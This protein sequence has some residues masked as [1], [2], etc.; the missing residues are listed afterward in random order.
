MSTAD[1]LDPALRAR[2]AAA[3]DR[4]LALIDALDPEAVDSPEL[5]GGAAAQALVQLARGPAREERAL[6]WAQRAVALSSEGELHYGLYTGLVGV[7][8]AVEQ[9]RPPDEDPNA[10][11]DELL[12][13]LVAE[14]GPDEN[15]DLI[16]GLTGVA[17]LAAERMPAPGAAALLEAVAAVVARRAIPVPG[18][19]LWDTNPELHARAVEAGRDLQPWNLGVSHGA[20]GP[21]SALALAT[22]WGLADHGALID[23]ALAALLAEDRPDRSFPTTVGPDG[24][25]TGGRGTAW[26]YGGLG[27]G[28]WLVALGDLLGRAPL[29]ARGLEMMLAHATRWPDTVDAALCHGELGVA[30][31][32]ARAAPRDPRLVAP[33]R[34]LLAAA[35]DRLERGEGL[36]A[37]GPLERELLEGAPGAALALL[38]ILDDGPAPVER[39]LLSALRGPG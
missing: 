4:L 26:C 7:C 31:L 28:A 8:W 32:L 14:V 38:A 39:L 2:A 23:R 12:L 19:V 34:R 37:T 5:G 11:M 36:P 33:T 18:G 21:I 35:L 3:L 9:L 6:A 17:V 10:D 22:A 15:L 29:V 24:A 25:H 13:G 20:P 27:V 1:L 30:M 16:G